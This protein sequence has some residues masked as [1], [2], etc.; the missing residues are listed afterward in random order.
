MDFHSWLVKKKYL[1][2]HAEVG[3]GAGTVK[4]AFSYVD[5]LNQVRTVEYIADEHGFYPQLS[6]PVKNTKAVDLATQ[7][8]LNLYNKIAQQ[9]SDPNYVQAVSQPRQSAAVGEL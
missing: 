8:H 5:P 6:H 7:R 4:G 2:T 3:D 9:H 1:G